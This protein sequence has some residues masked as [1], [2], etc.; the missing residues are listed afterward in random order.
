MTGSGFSASDPVVG[1]VLRDLSAHERTRGDAPALSRFEML[2]TLG[3]GATAVVHRA[4]DRVL[5]REVAVKVLRDLAGLTETARERFRREAQAA[6]GLAHPNVVAVHDAGE[7]GGRPFLVMELV[8]GRPLSELLKGDR[9]GLLPL[10]EKAARGVAAAHARGIVHRDLKPANILVTA[11]GEP[12]V[13][14]FG[15][16]HV[17]ETR[18][19]LTR[20]GTAVGTP[21][22]MAPE[23][24]EGRPGGISPRTD[25]YA[26]GAILY[27]VLSGRPPHQGETLAELYRKIVRDDPAGPGGARDPSVIA[28]KAL[29]KD[30]ARRYSDAGEFADD[31]R[32]HLA[33]EPILARPAGRAGRFLR[34]VRRH[35]MGF[36]LG[37][38]TLAVALLAVQVARLQSALPDPR[39]WTPV[40]DGTS[41]ACFMG[42]APDGWRL[43][44][45]ELVTEQP[46]RDS[47]QT[48]RLFDDGEVRVRFVAER[49]SYLGFN[50]R[51][52]TTAGYGVSW[53]RRGVEQMG[54]AERSLVFAM[55][56]DDVT[57]TLDGAP[58][59]VERRGANRSGTLH[60]GAVG[61][62]LRIRSIEF[63]PLR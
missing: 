9:S 35:P 54:G 38:A 24:V 33:G 10:L 51:L 26:L 7:E 47:V 15:L 39:P 12:K 58:L 30:P 36:A 34:K 1:R 25:V 2:G 62:A 23:Q 41:L 45:G 5:G 8:E 32:R 11:G 56:G 18:S 57:A 48:D 44:K 63:R 43:Q 21:L 14:D 52:G 17:L 6:A 3:E 42:G 40:F 13:G 28:M 37:A 49:T 60:F 22:Y 19:E 31:L 59:P 46:T 20:T 55:R 16:A 4:R 27:E 50:I 29:E 53:D 61:G